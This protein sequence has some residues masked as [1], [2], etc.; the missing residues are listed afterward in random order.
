[1]KIHEITRR[2]SN[3]TK[4]NNRDNKNDENQGRIQAYT[5]Y[6]KCRGPGGPQGGPGGPQ[7]GDGGAQGGPQGALGAQGG[8]YARTYI[9]MEDLPRCVLQNCVPF[10]AAA[11]KGKKK[12]EN[13]RIIL[14]GF[15]RGLNLILLDFFKCFL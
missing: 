6:T 9:R 7:G 5:P 10:G 14:Q 1:M 8:M 2:S 4:I 3:H 12:E 15:L 11:Q 13:N